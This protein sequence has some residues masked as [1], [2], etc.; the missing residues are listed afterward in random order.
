[1]S[2][3]PTERI[4][5]LI[6]DDH[7]VVRKG[8]RGYLEAQPDLSI[9]G[10][11]ASGEE[12]V[13]LAA[14]HTPDVILMDLVLAPSTGSGHGPSTGSGHGPSTSSGHGP[15][16][17]SGHGMDG[18]EATRRVREVSPGSQVIVLTSYHDDDHIFPAIKAGALSYLLKNVRP[19]ELADAVRAAARGEATLD[20]P[21]A[22]RVLQEMRESL[23]T[24][25]PAAPQPEG[26]PLVEPL[27]ERELEVLDLI[28]TGLTNP[29]IADRLFIAKGTVKRHVNNIYGKL[30]VHHRAEAIA[31]ARNLGLLS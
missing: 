8:V 13:R 9:A 6:V 26:Q 23:A 20:S 30:Q 19:E 10:E 11:A 17:S 14:E 5:V 16:T 2:E 24:E 1:M 29:E 4:S 27:S 18:V 12:A 22:T 21:V 31:R 28:A 25:K 7:A 15:S 3:P